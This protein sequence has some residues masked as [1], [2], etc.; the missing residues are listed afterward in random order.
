MQLVLKGCTKAALD[1]KGRVTL[2]ARCR[3]ALEAD[4]GN[5][6]VA[7]VDL[8]EQC[9]LLY[10]WTAWQPI[11]AALMDLPNMDERYRR[12]QRMMLGHAVEIEIDGSGRVLLSQELRDFAR[13]DKR[14]ALVGQ[15]NKFELWSEEHWDAR[16]AEWRRQAAEDLHSLGQ[17]RVALLDRI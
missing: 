17:E 4:G 9:L 5:V 1:L 10:S 6:V 14:V 3:E 16:R 2:P 7:T 11:E 15:G 8:R 13:L 12:L